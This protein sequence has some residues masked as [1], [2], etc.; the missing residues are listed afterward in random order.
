M[1]RI[2]IIRSSLKNFRVYFLINL[3]IYFIKLKRKSSE[4][5]GYM[6]R[7]KSSIKYFKK[8]FLR[9]EIKENAIFSFV[10]IKL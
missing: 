7:S 9:V 3:P 1:M 6:W 5:D 8:L 10:S 4:R 2:N